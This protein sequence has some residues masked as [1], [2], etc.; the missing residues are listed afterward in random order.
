MI[1]SPDIANNYNDL[2]TARHRLL[3]TMIFFEFQ[4]DSDL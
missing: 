4:H 1:E 2:P 3:S